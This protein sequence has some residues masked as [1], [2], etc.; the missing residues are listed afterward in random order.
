M[1]TLRHLRYVDALARLRHFGQAAAAVGVTQPAL[2]MQIREVE[3][4]L[5]GLL[6]ER[7]PSGAVPTRL[8]EEFAV[9]AARIIAEM[10]DLEA[11]GR[12]DRALSHN[13]LRLGVIPSIAPYLLPRLLPLMTDR[14]PQIGVQLREAVTDSLVDDL[15]GGKIDAMIASL[16]LRQGDFV[17]RPAFE[18]EFLLAVPPG[19]SLAVRK[20]VSVAEIDQSELILLEDG[21]CLRDQALAVC[22]IVDPPQLRRFGASSLSTILHMVAAGHG[23]TLAPR[24]AMGEGDADNSGLCVIPFADPAPSRTVGLAWR[25]TSPRQ[26]V[27]DQLAELVAEAASPPKA[28]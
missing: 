25:R 8:G 3:A 17:E 2:S 11:I 19:S 23:I 13:R 4:L 7:T 28:H 1:L 16:P 24:L 22:G 6:F 9:R 20:K 27:F 12:G 21:H 15:A 26:P 10:D 18:D 5:G 14:M